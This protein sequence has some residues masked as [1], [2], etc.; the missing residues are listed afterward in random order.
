VKLAI[1]FL[2]KNSEVQTTYLNLSIYFK[3][4]IL[5]VTLFFLFYSWPAQAQGPFSGTFLIGNLADII[6]T[7]QKRLAL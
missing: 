1:F 6:I 2:N 4:L 7:T 5:L 3:E